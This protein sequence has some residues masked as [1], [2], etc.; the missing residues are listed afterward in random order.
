MKYRI[1][2]I[3]LLSFIFTTEYNAQDIHLSQ[4]YASDHLLNPSKMGDFDGDFRIAGNY[5]NQWRQI[6]P[7]VNKG[8]T[9]SII[10][11]DKAFRLRSDEINLGLLIAHDEFGGINFSTNKILLSGA[12]AF[13][14]GGH[15]L[16]AGVQTGLVFRNSDLSAQTFPVQWD[17]PTGS[18]NT[19]APNMESALSPSLNY[20][21]F[22]V[23][24]QWSKEFGKLKPKLGVALNHLNRPR[25]SYFANDYFSESKERLRVRNVIHGEL[26]YYHSSKLTIQ[27]KFLL[28]STAKANDFI[29]GSNFRCKTGNKVIPAIFGGVFYR[30]GIA[31]NR[32]AVYPVIGVNYL[33]NFDLGFSYDVNISTLS[34]NVDRKGTFEVSIIYIAPNINSKRLTVPCERY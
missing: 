22:N 10:S 17:Y 19:A 1:L 12:Y 8:I 3:L 25:D 21:D 26:E 14:L 13:E 23:G 20:F 2:T 29:I 27:P 30:D 9:T 33:K 15:N 18:F 32:D 6:N 11:F 4:F 16:R 7:P 5:R 24:V 28:M 31:T 34:Q